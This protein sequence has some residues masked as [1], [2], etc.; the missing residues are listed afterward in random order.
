MRLSRG[1]RPLIGNSGCW[2]TALP[3][4]DIGEDAEDRALRLV[5]AALETAAPGL[6][7]DAETATSANVARSS[8]NAYGLD[9]QRPAATSSTLPIDPL[10]AS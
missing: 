6:D 5:F 8:R 10:P 7:T 2:T 9:S 1:T 3:W 4:G